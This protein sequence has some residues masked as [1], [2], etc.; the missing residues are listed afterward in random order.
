MNSTQTDQELPEG[1][2]PIWSKVEQD[3]LGAMLIDEISA[4]DAL[5]MLD[6]A[7]FYHAQN[8]ALF[9][10]MRRMS[11]NGVPVNLLTVYPEMQ[12][13]GLYDAIGGWPYLDSIMYG[14]PD[15]TLTGANVRHHIRCLKEQAVGR[16]LSAAAAELEAEVRLGTITYTQMEGSLEELQEQLMRDE[17]E[18]SEGIASILPRVTKAINEGTNDRGVSTGLRRLDQMVRLQRKRLYL[19]VSR[20]GVGKTALVGNIVVSVAE[21]TG[22]LVVFFTLE[23]PRDEVATRM[24]CTKTR[25]SSR[26]LEAEPDDEDNRLTAEDWERISREEE[27]LSR[28]PIQFE[29]WSGVGVSQI[30]ARARQIQKQIDFMARNPRVSPEEQGRRREVY[31][32]LLKN[33]PED[34][35]GPPTPSHLALIVVDHIGEL[36]GA[37]ENIVTQTTKISQ[38]LKQMA[39]ELDVPVVVLAHTSRA[40]EKREDRKPMLA[41]LRNAGEAAA[42]TV[43]FIHQPKAG[44]MREDDGTDDGRVWP[45]EL[46]LEKNRGGRRG[47]AKLQYA[48]AYFLFTDEE[49]RYGEPQP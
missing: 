12:R 27:K 34:T 18:H 44:E 1:I 47:I 35:D 46:F 2:P 31:A 40:I 42:D 16:H 15:R 9:G 14:I 25:I 8:Q 6:E 36:D 38:Q 43:M 23:M 3:V 5:Q 39:K 21:T 37:G 49:D 22:G 19:L 28:L 30:L 24:L 26:Q 7:D 33:C 48:P 17:D 10:L 29:E 32:K 45:V 20:P 41:D 13:A 4:A 11:D